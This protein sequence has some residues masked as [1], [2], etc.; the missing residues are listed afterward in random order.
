MEVRSY[1]FLQFESKVKKADGA[2]PFEFKDLL[3]GDPRKTDRHQKVIKIERDFAKKSNFT[4]SPIVRQHRGMDDQEVEEYEKRVL[5]EVEKRLSKIEEQAFA[6]GYEDGKAKGMEEIFNQTRA[7]TEAKLEH[8]SEII[9]QV[10]LYKANLLE[11]EKH[12]VYRMIKN[13]AKW[14]ILRELK[15]DG[16]YAKRLLEKLI[17]ELQT[18]TNLLIKVNKHYFEQMPEVLEHI[19]KKL[20][21]LKNVRVEIGY[22][23]EGPGM[24]VESENGIINGDLA[25]QFINL[26]KL[27]AS[28]G[29]DE[30]DPFPT[31]INESSDSNDEGGESE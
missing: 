6:K 5:D 13:L 20:G 21:L 7:E 22:D 8:L 1:E 24:I 18:K 28:L 3:S 12:E 4:I 17:L 9:N 25:Q 27:F 30:Q 2:Q 10:M 26:D 31:Q 16:E 23:I 14:I 29:I 11:N 19:E 15:D